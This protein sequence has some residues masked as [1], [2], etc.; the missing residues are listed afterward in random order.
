[1]VNSHISDDIKEDGVEDFMGITR[2]I[3]PIIIMTAQEIFLSYRLKLLT[4]PIDYIVPAIWG[5]KK[6]GKLDSTQKEIAQKV[7]NVVEE[8]FEILDLKDLNRA[9]ELAIGFLIRSLFI[10]KISYFINGVKNMVIQKLHLE[11]QDTNI[12]SHLEWLGSA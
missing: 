4:E 5:A 8:L 9:Q 6:D 7:V 1:M 11:S 12:L 2:A 3:R 10:A